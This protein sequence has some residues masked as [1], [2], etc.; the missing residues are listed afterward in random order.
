MLDWPALA[1]SPPRGAT[2]VAVAA[3]QRDSN[4]RIVV[5]VGTLTTIRRDLT[6]FHPIR[7]TKL[8][9]GSESNC[10]SPVPMLNITSHRTAWRNPVSVQ[11]NACRLDSRSALQAPPELANQTSLPPDEHLRILIPA[12]AHYCTHHSLV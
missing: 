5:Q 9:P 12:L 10:N 8:T 1:L 6:S 11:S 4:P 3:R 7:L 2:K